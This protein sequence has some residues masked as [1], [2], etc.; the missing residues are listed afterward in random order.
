MP[1][2][3]GLPPDLL[4]TIIRRETFLVGNQVQP[5]LRAAEAERSA[6]AEPENNP[7]GDDSWP[8]GDTL[9]VD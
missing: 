4:A 8:A 2:P 6:E 1:V 3:P 7:L 9:P 5:A